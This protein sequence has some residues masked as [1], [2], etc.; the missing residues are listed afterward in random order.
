[1]NTYEVTVCAVVL[2]T[3]KVEAIDFDDAKWQAEEGF[4]LYKRQK[5]TSVE[6]TY[7]HDLKKVRT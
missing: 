7:L 6:Q 2:Q 5:H 4:D 3:F 1:M